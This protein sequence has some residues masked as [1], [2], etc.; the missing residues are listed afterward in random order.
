MIFFE[1]ILKIFYSIAQNDSSEMTFAANSWPALS[2]PEFNHLTISTFTD[3]HAGLR[4]T[5]MKLEILLWG[6]EERNRDLNIV[7]GRK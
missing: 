1:K 5:K 4:D 7:Q 6:V 3:I 2:S